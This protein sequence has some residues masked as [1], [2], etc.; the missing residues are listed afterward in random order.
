MSH[1]ETTDDQDHQPR[2]VAEITIEMAPTLIETKEG[3]IMIATFATGPSH[4]GDVLIRQ[5]T[6]SGHQTELLMVIRT[7]YLSKRAWLA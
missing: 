2:R 1:I 4:H 7:S 5:A 6:E 3:A